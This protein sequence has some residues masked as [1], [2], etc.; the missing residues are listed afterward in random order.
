MC[1]GGSERE[2]DVVRLMRLRHAQRRFRREL[3]ENFHSYLAPVVTQASPL[4]LDICAAWDLDLDAMLRRLR[5]PAGWPYP[6]T[7]MLG[8]AVRTPRVTGTGAIGEGVQVNVMDD[9]LEVRTWLGEAFVCTCDG[10][11]QLW[12]IDRIPETVQAGLSGRELSSVVD[13]PLLRMRPYR[14]IGSRSIGHG[15]VINAEAPLVP[16]TGPWA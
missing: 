12:L 11:L 3:V 16:Y 2:P 8:R 15:T 5:P 14:I 1:S 7:K 10:E 6:A 9:T 4:L 13:H